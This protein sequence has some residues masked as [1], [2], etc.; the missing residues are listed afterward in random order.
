MTGMKHAQEYTAIARRNAGRGNAT[1]GEVDRRS[2]QVSM[3]RMAAAYVI[4][5]PGS[6]S[7]DYTGPVETCVDTV[8]CP[9]LGWSNNPSL[10]R[11]RSSKTERCRYPKPD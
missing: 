1:P 9:T 6:A 3:R 11:L 5:W 10:L 7:D 8:V 4:L 2:L